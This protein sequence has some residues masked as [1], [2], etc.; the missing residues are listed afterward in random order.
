MTRAP[1]AGIFEELQG[2]SSD[3]V[4]NTEGKK[5]ISQTF[6]T[7][8]HYCTQSH[9]LI[10]HIQSAAVHSDHRTHHGSHFQRACRHRRPSPVG[11]LR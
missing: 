8:S 9:L 1:S 4:Q 10:A 2:G 7:T 5:N 6:V 11:Q 3:K